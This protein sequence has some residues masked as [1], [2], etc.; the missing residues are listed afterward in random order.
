MVPIEISS[1]PHSYLTSIRTIGLSCTVWPQY[2]MQQTD[3]RQ[4]DRNRPPTLQHQWPK[5]YKTCGIIRQNL[6]SHKWDIAYIPNINQFGLGRQN[7]YLV[8]SSVQNSGSQEGQTGRHRWLLIKC[9][10]TIVIMTLC[11]GFISNNKICL[12]PISFVFIYLTTSW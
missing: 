7:N 6:Q 2:T 12:I 4:S 11:Y 1:S 8:N 3:D 10:C 9:E 5:N